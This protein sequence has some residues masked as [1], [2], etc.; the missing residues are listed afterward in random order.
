MEATDGAASRLE[1]AG[2][3]GGQKAKYKNGFQEGI[4]HIVKY[5]Y[6]LLKEEEDSR[7]T[8]G[9]VTDDHERVRR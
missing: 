1:E 5:Y 4:G 2:R 9:F 8:I 7:L 3:Y 6:R